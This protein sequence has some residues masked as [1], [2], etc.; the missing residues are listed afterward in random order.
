MK[1]NYTIPQISE[2]RIVFNTTLC[3]SSDAIVAPD[4]GGFDEKG[5]G[6]LNLAPAKP[7]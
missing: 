6:N 3:G 2:Y 1:K 4:A 5:G 7:F